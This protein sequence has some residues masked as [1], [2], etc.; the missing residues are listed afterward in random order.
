MCRDKDG[1]D[2]DIVIRLPL[3]LS[4]TSRASASRYAFPTVREVHTQFVNRAGAR[5]V[6]MGDYGWSMDFGTSQGSVAVEYGRVFPPHLLFVCLSNNLK[7]FFF[8][9]LSLRSILMNGR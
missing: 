8:M 2:D 4:R 3:Q 5:V 9:I 7:P 6:T 1:D